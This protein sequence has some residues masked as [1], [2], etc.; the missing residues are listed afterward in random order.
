LIREAHT[1]K[2]AGHFVVR[3][4]VANLQGY[5]YWPKMQEQFSKSI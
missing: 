5:V 3:K 1:K 2:I 4:I